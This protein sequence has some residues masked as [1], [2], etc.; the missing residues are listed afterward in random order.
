[1][2]FRTLGVI[3][4]TT[5]FVL[6]CNGPTAPPPRAPRTPT[7]VSADAAAVTALQTS[8]FA[9]ANRL[10]TEALAHDPR[11]SRAAA[12]RAIATYQATGNRLVTELT[13]VLEAS[14][15]LQ[16]LD[17][18]TGRA[19]WQRFA[20]ALVIVDRDL[21]IAATD[22]D[23][24][25]ELCLACWEHDWNR[26]G[27]IDERDRKMFEL[28]YDDRGDDHLLPEGDPRRRPT[29]KF[30]VGDVE[31]ARAMISFQRA[32]VELVLAYRW[33][34]LDKLFTEGEALKTAK[35]VLHLADPARVRHA[36]ELIVAGL[37]AAARCRTAYLAETDD[38][39]E[40]V[41]NPAQ[42]S[43]PIPLDADAALFETWAQVVGDLGDLLT[44]KT[45]L[46]I[47]QLAALGDD[48]F[49]D[50]VPDAFIDLGAMLREPQDLVLDVGLVL[51]L[52]T[53]DK[54]VLRRTAEQLIK[55]LIGKGYVPKATRSPI[56]DRLE[57]MKHDLDTGHDTFE[58][59][60]RY[61]LWLN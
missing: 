6:A 36:R 48:D 2:R 57:R 17:H 12:V 38:D 13:G 56:V 10:A 3:A 60:L 39:R 1:M 22:P 23:F 18:E 50:L 5:S 47:R 53:D 49:P 55:D 29:F 42:R 45:A 15:P 54:A 24:T 59:K 30:D 61:L 43:H 27:R 58:R 33:N 31:W 32:A 20:D 16:L 14:G 44:S 26:N 46:S 8:R 37:A 51:R 28:E 40:W 4:L 19:A 35:V 21:A 9:D 52:R 11:S 34:E 7:Q 41:P 25:L